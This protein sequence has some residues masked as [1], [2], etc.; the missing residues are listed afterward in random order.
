[1]NNFNR[2]RFSL[3]SLPDQKT[4]ITRLAM[5]LSLPEREWLYINSLCYCN[6]ISIITFGFPWSPGWVFGSAY[7]I[8]F[9]YSYACKLCSF[10]DASSNTV[11]SFPLLKGDKQPRKT[12]KKVTKVLDAGM[13][14]NA[15]EERGQQMYLNML[16]FCTDEATLFPMRSKHEKV[17]YSC[18]CQGT[19]FRL[20]NNNNFLMVYT[21]LN[22]ERV[23]DKVILFL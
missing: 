16:G 8:I 7:Q 18:N 13:F 1:M 20:K 21:L 4:N 17:K 14:R 2:G 6:F 9:K 22:L 11:A 10:S 15:R 23:K 12:R 19:Y 3:I 5:P